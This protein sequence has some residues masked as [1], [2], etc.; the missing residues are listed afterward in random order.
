MLVSDFI[1]SKIEQEKM[2]FKFLIDDLYKEWLNTLEHPC[3][4]ATM[5]NFGYFLSGYLKKAGLVFKKTRYLLNGR[6]RTFYVI[7]TNQPK[8]KK[9]PV[10]TCPRCGYEEPIT[11][12]Q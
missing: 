10:R 4:D 7:H 12:E 11:K 9:K 1:K 3:H 2:P 6:K 8:T 5:Q